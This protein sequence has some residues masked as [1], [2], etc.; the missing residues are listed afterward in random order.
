LAGK[1]G[2]HFTGGRGKGTGDCGGLN[3]KKRK[4]SSRGSETKYGQVPRLGGYFGG[5]VT[6]E[7]KKKIG[8]IGA[9]KKEIKKLGKKGSKEVQIKDN[10]LKRKRRKDVHTGNKGEQ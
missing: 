4:R 10:K 1:G 5:K 8:V 7:K 9:K 6:R 2:N 3:A